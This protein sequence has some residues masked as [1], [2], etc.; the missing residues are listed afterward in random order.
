MPTINMKN[1]YIF[2]LAAFASVLSACHTKGDKAATANDTSFFIGTYSRN[3]S[4]GIYHTTISPEGKFKGLS[5]AAKARNASFIRKTAN[6]KML[7]AVSEEVEGKVLSFQINDTLLSPVD[8]ASTFGAHPCHISIH[9]AQTAVISNY[10]GGNIALIHMDTDGQLSTIDSVQF[11]G[12]GPHPRQEASHAHSTTFLNDTHMATA[13]LGSDQII[14][15]TLVKE[16]QEK[17]LRVTDTIALAPAA[18]PRHM[19]MAA[20]GRYGYVINELNSTI[21]LIRK[22]KT[23][24]RYTPAQTITTLPADFSG[25]NFCADIHLDAT[26][27]FLYASNRG[28]QSIAIYKVNTENGALTPIGFQEV[29]GAWPRNFAISPDNKFLVVANEHSE[30]LVCFK[31]DLTTGKLDKTDEL[32]V[33]APVCIAF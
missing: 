32:A 29:F 5:L 8:S 30:N 23:T 26:G 27:N 22:N 14:I 1:T 17:Q 2:L 10:S 6:H 28:H 13:N 16:N 12:Q 20:S 24:E 11:Q 31:R 3:Q 19:V 9:N 4:K 7:L 15:S 18:G 25:E 33:P 21:T